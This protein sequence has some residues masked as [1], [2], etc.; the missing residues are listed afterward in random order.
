MP[1]G[2]SDDMVLQADEPVPVWGEAIGQQKNVAEM[3]P[4][5]SSTMKKKLLAWEDKVKPFLNN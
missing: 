3:H 1:S 5:R 2:F 4:E